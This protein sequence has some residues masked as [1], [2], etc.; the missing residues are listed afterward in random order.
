MDWTQMNSNYT[1]KIT[2]NMGGSKE[3]DRGSHPLKNHKAIG[4]LSNTCPDPLKNHKA[5]K[6]AFNV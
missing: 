6:S 5:T 1:V 3:G 2:C 4:F